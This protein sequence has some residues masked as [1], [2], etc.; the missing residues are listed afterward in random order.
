MSASHR[1]TNYRNSWW[2]KWSRY[3]EKTVPY[4]RMSKRFLDETGHT[5]DDACWTVC[6]ERL[7]FSTNF[8][9][10]DAND[11]HE[12]WGQ[13][14]KG[15]KERQPFVSVAFL[16]WFYVLYSELYLCLYFFTFEICVLK[17][18]IEVFWQTDIFTCVK[19][20]SSVLHAVGQ[21]SC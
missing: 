2:K 11:V 9:T 14:V 7:A 6:Q 20:Y 13:F 1:T 5:Y 17:K 8:D 3:V 12:A 16:S 15:T 19:S 10:F 21:K 18:T 4:V